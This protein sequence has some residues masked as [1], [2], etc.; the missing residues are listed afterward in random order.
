MLVVNN[1]TMVGIPSAKRDHFF[2]RFDCDDGEFCIEFEI[3][4]CYVYVQTKPLG[5]A[6]G[7]SGGGGDVGDMGGEFG[8]TG[9]QK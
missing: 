7:G 9:G 3:N 8:K 6:G 4:Q 1:P 2:N 5:Q